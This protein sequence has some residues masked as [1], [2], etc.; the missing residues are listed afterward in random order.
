MSASI[1]TPTASFLIW[2]Q[3][4]S[5]HEGFLQYLKE[6]KWP[7][8]FMCLQCCHVPISMRQTDFLC[9]EDKYT[10]QR[11]EHKRQWMLDRIYFSAQ[12]L[13]LILPLMLCHQSIIT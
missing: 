6:T 10:E 9:G 1:N 3:Q 13:L 5:T 8:A 4:F 12:C 11:Y 7:N 2:Q